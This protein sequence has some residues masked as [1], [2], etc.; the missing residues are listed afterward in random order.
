M[1]VLRGAV[2]QWKRSRA[3]SLAIGPA[4]AS[5]AQIF[6]IASRCRR[7]SS[8]SMSGQSALTRASSKWT[9]APSQRRPIQNA[10]TP[11]LMNSSRSTR[12][13][14]RITAK[15]KE[16]GAGTNGLLHE[17]RRG[18]KTAQQVVDIGAA[19]LE[20]FGG[21]FFGQQPGIGDLRNNAGEDVLGEPRFKRCDA[22]GPG[23]QHVIANG[24]E[25]TGGGAADTGPVV[26]EIQARAVIDAIELFM[27]P[28]QIRI[29]CGAIDIADEGVEPDHR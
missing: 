14:M 19:L 21:A 7:A 29:A 18:V 24:G 8:R 1:I 27:P 11:A 13:T 17:Q 6:G 26:M 12:G 10:M 28:E 16:S 22:I 3:E 20:R 9:R 2:S 15:S 23:Q 4:S 5:P 25:R